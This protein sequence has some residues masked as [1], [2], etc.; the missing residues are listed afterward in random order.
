MK[1]F[2]GGKELTV[3]LFLETDCSETEDRIGGKTASRDIRAY[4][5]GQLP[6]VRP[7]QGYRGTILGIYLKRAKS[8]A[9]F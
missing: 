6:S 3:C 8:K 7:S 2:P 5:T 9:K 4:Q 1:K